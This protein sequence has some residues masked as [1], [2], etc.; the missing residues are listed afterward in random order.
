MNVFAQLC[1]RVDSAVL[2]PELRS[3]SIGLDAKI[4][5]QTG[6]LGIGIAVYGGTILVSGNPDGSD[7]LIHAEKDAWE[8]VLAS[9]PPPTFHSFT[10]LQLANP[11]F[12]VSGDAATIARCRPMLERLFE[13]VV[14]VPAAEPSERISRDLSKVHGS[15][16]SVQMSGLEYQVYSERS[17]TG[18]PVLFLHTAGADSRQFHG[19]LSDVELASHYKMIAPDLPFHGRSMPSPNWRG[20]S[21]KLDKALYLSWCE[22][23]LNSIVGEPAIIVGGSMGAAM[24]LVLAAE[25]P[26]LVRGVVAVEPPFR[27]KGRRNPFQHHASVH[28]SL[29]NASYVRG[30]MSPLSPEAN[31]RHAA[32]IYSQGA[33]GIYPGDLA[34]YSDEFDGATVGPKIDCERTP[35]MLLCGDYDYSATPDDGRK[36]LEVMPGASMLEMRGLG[37]FPMC[38]D[39]NAFRPYMLAALQAIT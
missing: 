24:A 13:L 17:G 30:L 29:H 15:Y 3:V 22:G 8:K 34:F 19:Q 28:G 21:Y 14:K 7:V 27:S 26:E 33:P 10:A 4:G 25:R 12:E 18:K 23:I 31:R 2:D 36:L 1:S 35:V 39:P 9:P 37:H 16:T 38:E 32:W 6:C 20:E 11:L 5:I